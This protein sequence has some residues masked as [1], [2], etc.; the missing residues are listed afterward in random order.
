MT[1][2]YGCL[3]FAVTSAHFEMVRLK[4]RYLICQILEPYP[5]APATNS[6]SSSS[7]SYSLTEL[8]NVLREKIFVLYGDSGAF[9]HT[10]VRYF[11][12]QSKL[13]VVRTNREFEIGCK[14]A[15]SLIQSIKKNTNT[16][17]STCIRS[18]CSAGSERSCKAKLMSYAFL[19][20]DM[21][22]FESCEMEEKK[23]KITSYENTIHAIDL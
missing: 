18:L 21:I 19:Y 3:V 2:T 23:A 10:G 16:N 1:I 17:G 5:T 22:Y 4:R 7:V 20:V 8:N 13:L 6:L 12:N 11:D 14:L 15:L 9:S